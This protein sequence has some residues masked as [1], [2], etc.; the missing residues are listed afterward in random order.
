MIGWSGPCYRDASRN[1]VTNANAVWGANCVVLCN[2]RGRGSFQHPRKECGED[3]G[4]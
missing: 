4:F 2:D 3:F 1:R